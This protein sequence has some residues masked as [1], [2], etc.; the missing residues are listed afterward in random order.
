M[1]NRRRLLSALLAAVL[2]LGLFLPARV[3]AADLYFTGINDSVAPLTSDTMP[4][5]S[6]GILYVPYTVFSASTNGIGVDLGLSF[7]YNSRNSNTITLYNNSKILSFDL[8]NGTCKDE[9]TGDAYPSRAVMR[10]GRPYLPLSMVCSFFGLSYSYTSLP[11]IPQGYLVRIKNSDVV[12]PDF[13]FVDAAGDLIN[14][15]LRE[16]TQ[17]LSPGESTSPGTTTPAYPSTTDDPIPSNSVPTYL[18]V[19][20][21]SADGI[22]SML[23]TL[24]GSGRY[25]LFFMDP[26]LLEKE[27]AL[28]R[29]IL[30]TGHS[31]GILAQG[32]DPAQTRQLLA[33]GNSAL[34]ALFHTRTTLAYVPQEHQAALEQE[35]WVCWKETMLLSPSSAVGANSYAS[36]TVRRLNSKARSVYLTLEGSS[37]G[38]RVLSSLLRQL[39]NEHFVVSIPME[40]KL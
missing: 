30:G 23:T 20:C 29:R 8:A 38:A 25:A 4:F 37:D 40:T 14:R 7:S 11:S 34:E 22:S 32:S 6:G 17:S 13:R 39:A 3:S 15:R 27:G 33:Q 12:L 28:V 1:K 2:C 35:G 24:E 10:N 21:R 9:L 36:T 19:L 18:S 26:Q 31:V 5:W 16:Y